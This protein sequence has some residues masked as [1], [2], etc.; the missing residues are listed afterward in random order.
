MDSFDADGKDFFFL[1]G[2]LV[3]WLIKRGGVCGAYT[4]IYKKRQSID[5]LPIIDPRLSPTFVRSD[6][7]T[8]PSH[9]FIHPPT[10]QTKPTPGINHVLLLAAGSGIA[11]IRAAIE[12]EQ[13]GLK[14]VSF[15]IGILHV[16]MFVGMD[17][18]SVG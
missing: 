5:R 3:G 7:F 9:L 10:N 4:Y 1:V 2:W 15:F 6:R 12:S 17:E 8:T 14:K 16:H 18:G 13:L 11:P